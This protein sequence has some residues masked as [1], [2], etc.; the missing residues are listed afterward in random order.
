MS[1]KQ[2]KWSCSLHGPKHVLCL[3]SASIEHAQVLVVM[4]LCVQSWQEDDISNAYYAVSPM[5]N[6]FH[7]A[8]P[9]SNAFTQSSQTPTRSQ[10]QHC[11]TFAGMGISNTH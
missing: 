11:C 10:V 1:D 8:A 6:V 7:G 4:C 2:G 5:K 9:G 3:F